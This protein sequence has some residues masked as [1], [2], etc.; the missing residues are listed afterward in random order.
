MWFGGFLRGWC[1]FGCLVGF[2]PSCAVS[3][4]RSEK[5]YIVNKL[6][7]VSAEVLSSHTSGPALLVLF[8]LSVV[9]VAKHII[10]I[11]IDH[12]NLWPNGLLCGGGRDI[13][14]Q[15]LLPRSKS[16]WQHLVP[17]LSEML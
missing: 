8:L 5:L 16:N 1:G 6:S 10:E 7:L 12:K 15:A 17:H 2:F 11:Q 9:T 3:M 13:I 4:V 14:F